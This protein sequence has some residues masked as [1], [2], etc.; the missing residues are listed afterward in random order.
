M[1]TLRTLLGTRI[2]GLRKAKELTQAEFASEIGMDYRYL[3]GIERGEINVTIDT[4]EKISQ[5]FEIEPYQLFLFSGQPKS[6]I[7]QEE[8]LE[9][10]E[11]AS[12]EMKEALTQVVAIMMRL[13]Q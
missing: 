6:K 13:Q 5:G 2:R 3:G 11:T 4:L 7:A 10:L 8:I 12:P 9:I 1:E